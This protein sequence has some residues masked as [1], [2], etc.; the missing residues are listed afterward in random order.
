MTHA[1]QIV[2]QITSAYTCKGNLKDRYIEIIDQVLQEQR[3]SCEIKRIE[4]LSKLL[5][6]AKTQEE[7]EI[8]LKL[9]GVSTYSVREAGVE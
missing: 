6:N 8:L 1:E 7:A 5:N 3:D 4:C 2:K 9:I